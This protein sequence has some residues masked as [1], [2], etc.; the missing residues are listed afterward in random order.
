[1]AMFMVYVDDDTHKRLVLIE[2]ETGRAGDD[3]AS[4]AVSEAALEY[5]RHRKDDPARAAL[6]QGEG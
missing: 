1:M 6:S 2:A 4:D 5:F 3:L